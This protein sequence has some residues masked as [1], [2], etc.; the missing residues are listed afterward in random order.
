VIAEH[1]QMNETTASKLI[2]IR[3]KWEAII[4][5]SRFPLSRSRTAFTPLF[6]VG[7]AL[8]MWFRETQTSN[9]SFLIDEAVLLHKAQYFADKER[10]EPI[11][12]SVTNSWIHAWRRT[13]HIICMQSHGESA[14]ADS[15]AGDEWIK[16][17]YAEI[18]AS[19]KPDEIWSADETG[20]YW[21]RLPTVAL[22][23]RGKKLR[24]VKV[25]KNRVTVLL[26]C[27]LTGEKFV[28]FVIGTARS[29]RGFSSL[30]Q[31]H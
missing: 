13:N 17:V 21:R 11:G 24:G 6:V 25:S 3:K 14:S 26:C 27:S 4:A 28:P 12:T 9:P 2:K 29:P 16:T 8:L 7:I 30:P 15:A 18:C 31:G 1:F 22:T 20:L 19:F 10:I 5:S 23:E